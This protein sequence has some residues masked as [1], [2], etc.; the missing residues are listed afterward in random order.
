V[1]SSPFVDIWVL[2]WNGR[3]YLETCLPSVLGVNY[4]SFRV[5]VLDNGSTDGT[6][7][8]LGRT[9][10]QVQ[11]VALERN[12]GYAAANNIGM[13]RS[14]A[15]ASSYAILLNNDTRV[16]PD[17]LAA[18]VDAAEGDEN[19]AICQSRQRSWDGTNEIRFRLVPEWCA[20]ETQLS[21]LAPPGLPAP[22]PFA[23]GCSM[24]LRCAALERIGLLDE[25]YFM[26]FEDVDLSLRAWIAGWR[27]QDVPASIVYHWNSGT[28]TS[29]LRHVFWAYRNQLTTMLKLYQPQT[30]R[31]FW[32]PIVRRWFVTRN[33]YALRGTLSAMAMVAGTMAKR[34]AVQRGRRLPDAAFLSLCGS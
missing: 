3:R 15:D 25:R 34:A 8:W 17:W 9:F 23:S 1:S 7:A 30:L 18:L 24:L 28:G 4:P 29:P 19:V 22:T 32:R 13:A 21:G 12:L 10:P 16:E 33:R 2:N 6:Q 27:V 26:Y 14:L 31:Q 11:L 20:T 5:S